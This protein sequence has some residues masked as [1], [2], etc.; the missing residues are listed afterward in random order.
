MCNAYIDFCEA[1]IKDQIVL[2]EHIAKCPSFFTDLQNA[3][4]NLYLNLNLINLPQ[5]YSSV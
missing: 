2:R 1:P 4:L 5:A 3:I